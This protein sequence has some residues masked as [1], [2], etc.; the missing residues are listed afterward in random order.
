[1]TYFYGTPSFRSKALILGVWFAI[2]YE[3]YASSTETLIVVNNGIQLSFGT[4]RTWSNPIISADTTTLSTSEIHS[5]VAGVELTAIMSGYY[6]FIISDTNTDLTLSSPAENA[7]FKIADSG[8]LNLN[9]SSTNWANSITSSTASTASRAEIASTTTGTRITTA[10]LSRYYGFFIPDATKRAADLSIS[11]APNAKFKIGDASY[12]NVATLKSVITSTTTFG[13]SGYTGNTVEMNKNGIFDLVGQTAQLTIAH[14]VNLTNGTETT[15]APKIKFDLKTAHGGTDATTGLTITS[16]TLTT[17][18]LDSAI[19]SDNNFIVNF[20]SAKPCA[21]AD[22]P[23]TFTLVT[24]STPPTLKTEST[25][26]W[27]IDTGPDH[28]TSKSITVDGNAIKVTGTF[29]PTS[30]FLYTE[31]PSG[32]RYAD[33]ATANA[34]YITTGGALTVRKTWILNANTSLANHYTFQINANG[35]ITTNNYLLGIADSKTMALKGSGKF[36]GKVTFGDENSQVKFLGTSSMLI[37]PAD[38][39]VDWT[40]TASGMIIIGDGVH[41]AIESLKEGNFN[42]KVTLVTIET[43]SA[44]TLTK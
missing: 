10:D 28:W 34:D 36:K 18:G 13:D 41:T 44:L 27:A 19:D 9:V 21:V 15:A 33:F 7:K 42:D 29:N 16:G 22:T 43:G 2:L 3:C 5:T 31:A 26:T 6:G 14:G 12:T 17:D 39:T 24:G 1:M 25:G 40:S 8:R 23:T 4:A 20:D 35:S 30:L 11:N 38:F 32:H 37:D